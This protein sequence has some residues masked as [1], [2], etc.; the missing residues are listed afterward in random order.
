MDNSRDIFL[1]TS[2]LMVYIYRD[3]IAIYRD[4]RSEGAFLGFGGYESAWLTDVSWTIPE[5]YS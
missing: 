4:G 2:S 5:I 3:G 1:T